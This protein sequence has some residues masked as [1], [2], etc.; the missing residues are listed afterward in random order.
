MAEKK[1]ILNADNFGISNDLNRGILYAHNWGFLKSASLCANGE[2]FDN[3]IHEVLPECHNLGIGIQLNI[4]KGKSLSSCN[5]LT[6]SD[7][8]F[9]NSFFSLIRKSKNKAFL[10]QV[11]N[12]FR[13]QIEKVAKYTK[14]EHISS[15]EHIHAIPEIFKVTVKLA[16]EYGVEHIRTHKE[17]FYIV[18]NIFKHINLRYPLNITKMMLLNYFTSINI[19]NL[20]GLKTNDYIIG[21]SY[22]NMMDTQTIENGLEKIEFENAIVEAIIHPCVYTTGLKNNYHKEFE[23]TQNKSTEQKVYELGYKITNYRLN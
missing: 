3:A 13:A 22:A 12:E 4:S 8:E 1:F 7:G 15:Y 16:K 17:V 19:K 2:A 11:E 9:N 10:K 20:D 5:L 21:I 23:I 6:N 18:P 14:I